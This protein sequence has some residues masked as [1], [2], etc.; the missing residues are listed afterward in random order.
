MP[1]PYYSD[2]KH[3]AQLAI[4]HFALYLSSLNYLSK[5]REPLCNP[6]CK[7]VVQLF[8]VTRRNSKLAT[9]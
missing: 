6:L 2:A 8:F 5:L 9:K 1:E 7:L 4:L 3:I